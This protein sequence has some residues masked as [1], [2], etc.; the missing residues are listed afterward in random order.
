MAY[1]LS[2]EVEGR[3]RQGSTANAGY[4]SR[5]YSAQEL[6]QVNPYL[7]LNIRTL[8][9]KSSVQQNALSQR[10][11]E[12]T[13]YQILCRS[14]RSMDLLLGLIAFLG[15][16]VRSILLFFHCGMASARHA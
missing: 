14:E 5:Y 16:Y 11:R 1:A 8:C 12:I 15:W 4:P 3:F 9:C 7:W 10:I 2:Q 6:Q 13:G